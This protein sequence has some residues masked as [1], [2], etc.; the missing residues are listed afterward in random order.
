M[1]LYA[2]IAVVVQILQT[3]CSCSDTMNMATRDLGAR[4][5]R[6]L[7]LVPPQ[8]LR[9][10]DIGCD[11]GLLSGRL[12]HTPEIGSI[13]ATDISPQAAAGAKSLFASLDAGERAKVSLLIGDGL[14]P[15][16]RDSVEVDTVVLSG[17]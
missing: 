17:E 1:Y 16:V 9:I 15:L 12:A 2:W 3:V 4:F 11:H 6:L 14:S 7:S 8:T 10:A 13:F 5:N